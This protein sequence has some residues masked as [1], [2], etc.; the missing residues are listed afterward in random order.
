MNHHKETDLLSKVRTNL[1]EPIKIKTQETDNKP[2]TRQKKLS[3]MQVKPQILSTSNTP[4]P[5]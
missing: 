1:E 5:M 2:N 4:K 3:K